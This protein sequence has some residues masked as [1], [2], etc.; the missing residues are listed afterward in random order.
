MLYWIYVSISL[1]LDSI[2]QYGMLIRTTPSSH[3][4][5]TTAWFLPCPRSRELYFFNRLFS[6]ATA[7]RCY[8]RTRQ[9]VY[10]PR[11]AHP[12]SPYR[13]IHY[14]PHRIWSSTSRCTP[15][16]V[17]PRRRSKLHD[18]LP[19]RVSS[20]YPSQQWIL[21]HASFSRLSSLNS[22]PVRKYI[23]FAFRLLVVLR[24][25]SCLPL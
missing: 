19:G 7:E 14:S 17:H 10:R 5:T 8:S 4:Q 6:A 20:S 23:P 11:L 24:R 15:R 18:S 16:Y 21:C 2:L 9:H 1:F 3:F 22:C 13:R 12:L 25:G